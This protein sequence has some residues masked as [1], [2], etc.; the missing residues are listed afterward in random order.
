MNFHEF[1][2]TVRDYVAVRFDTEYTVTLQTVQKNNGV[3]YEGLMIMCPGR[4]MSPMIYLNPYYHRY[5]NGMSISEV[6]EDICHVYHTRLP[7]SNPDVSFFFDYAQ[8]RTRIVPKLIHYEKNRELLTDTPHIRYLDLVIVFLCLLEND[9]FATILIKNHHIGYWKT[10]TEDLYRASL[11]NA[12]L[13]LPAQLTG[14]RELLA[15]CDPQYAQT[16]IP[17][18]ERTMYVLSNRYRINGAAVILYE[19]VLSDIAAR[20]HSDLIVLPSSIHEVILVP[21]SAKAPKG[22]ECFRTMVREVNET[23]VSDDEI[24]SDQAY[25]FH[26]DTQELTV[27]CDPDAG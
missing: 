16:D 23:Q 4:N 24:L 11:C 19:H 18:A 8:V 17:D 5:L 20:F 25:Y 26:A 10:S 13:L 15:E 3:M 12:P 1:T 6:C 9:S 27:I 7:S 22:L 21:L 2:H 14:L